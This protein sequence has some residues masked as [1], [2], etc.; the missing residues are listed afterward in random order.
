MSASEDRLCEIIMDWFMVGEPS[1]KI[2]DVPRLLTMIE[3]DN[4]FI[5]KMLLMELLNEDKNE[6]DINFIR[7]LTLLA[8]CVFAIDLE[9]S[10]SKA[11][12]NN[13]ELLMAME[14]IRKRMSHTNRFVALLI[15]N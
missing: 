5:I 3:R 15:H 11:K 2:V 7:L 12:Q 1:L 9:N 4:D 14:E 13:K 10:I 8:S 6:K